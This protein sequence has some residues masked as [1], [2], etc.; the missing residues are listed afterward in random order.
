[1]DPLLAAVVLG[2]SALVVLVCASVRSVPAGHCGVVVRMGRTL[3][4]A[5]PGLLVVVPLLDR[6]ERVALGPRS[7]DPL[8]LTATTANGVEVRMA[9]NVLWEVADPMAVARLRDEPDAY[10]AESVERT[11][12]HMVAERDLGSL[13]HARH[14]VVAGLPGAADPLL[15][16]LGM[17]LVDVD[18]LDLEV[19]VG[20]EL[21][22]LLR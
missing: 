1:M 4:M 10:V 13:L 16:P 8:V 20:A 21:L 17:R 15:R 6:M 7:I 19:R 11:L 18:L 3:R 14:D 12:H 2:L 5:P 22:R 9:A